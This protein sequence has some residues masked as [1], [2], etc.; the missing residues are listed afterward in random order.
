MPNLP[1]T[2][3][4]SSQRLLFG[5]VLLLAT[6]SLSSCKSVESALRNIDLADLQEKTLNQPLDEKTI[7]SG[8]KEALRVGS[9]RAV[10]TSSSVDGYLGN[11]LIRIAMPGELTKTANTLRQIGLDAEVDK[12]EIAMNRAA[13][14]S[15]GQAREV[16]W[17]TITNMT[18][19][20][21]ISIWK[22]DDQAA[23]GYFRQKTEA[24][25]YSKFQPLVR[26]NMKQTG[27]YQLYNS[28]IAQYTA[29]PF[30]SK[31]QLDLDRYITQ[32]TLDGLFAVL[33]QEEANI[34]KNP[35]ARSTELLKK[36]FN[37]S[38]NYRQ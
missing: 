12:F 37:S 6:S 4:T 17:Q 8:L 27:L 3:S 36:V 33:G 34:R 24:Q 15:S 7:M 23:T 32:K 28:L 9:G 35:A 25:L 18:I 22:G 13:E 1:L 31:P 10:E 14:K 29:I 38:T 16:F 26:T 20:D 11:A 21:V 5:A 19:T 2:V 30:V